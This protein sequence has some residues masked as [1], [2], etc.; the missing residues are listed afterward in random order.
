MSFPNINYTFWMDQ[1]PFYGDNPIPATMRTSLIHYAYR[2]GLIDDIILNI[3]N[4]FCLQLVIGR[5]MI[6]QMYSYLFR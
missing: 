2:P 1:N 3:D 6:K 4:L 5:V